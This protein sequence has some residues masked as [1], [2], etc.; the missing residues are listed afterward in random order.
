MATPKTIYSKMKEI[1][2]KFLWGGVQQLKKWSLVAWSNL[3][4]PKMEGGVGLIDPFI[5]NQA[6]LWWIWA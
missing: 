3:I 5:L 4:K 6:K 2:K 1:F